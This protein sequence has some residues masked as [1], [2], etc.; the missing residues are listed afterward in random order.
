MRSVVQ[1]LR[2]FTRD[3]SDTTTDG[4]TGS[5]G[6]RE[7]GGLVV[8]GTRCQKGVYFGRGTAVQEAVEQM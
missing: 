7:R 2:R 5:Y 1:R 8:T 4:Y 6:G 3:E